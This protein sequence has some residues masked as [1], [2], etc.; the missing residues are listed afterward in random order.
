MLPSTVT[1]NLHVA[2]G[3]LARERERLYQRTAE[4]SKVRAWSSKRGAKPGRYLFTP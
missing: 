1:S 3:Y 2:S 4:N